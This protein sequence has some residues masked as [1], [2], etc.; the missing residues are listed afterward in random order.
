METNLEILTKLIREKVPRLMELTD[1]CI[2][3][4]DVKPDAPTTIGVNG[5]SISTDKVIVDDCAPGESRNKYQKIIKV[6]GHE[7]M[8]NDILEFYCT[9]NTDLTTVSSVDKLF[10]ETDN[11][12]HLMS[13]MMSWETSSPYLKNQ[14]VKI[15]SFILE[16]TKIPENKTHF[17]VIETYSNGGHNY[18]YFDSIPD[19]DTV[20]S[21]VVDLVKKSYEKK[22]ERK[23][24]DLFANTDPSE[25]T[26]EITEHPLKHKGLTFKTTWR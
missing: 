15:I 21:M 5:Y 10:K 9:Y 3:Y 6:I 8:L 2:V 25:P 12:K 13:V 20:C 1:G 16:T 4:T 23:E 17:Q 26:L 7:P 22:L 24:W 14:D 18:Y 11:I 19:E